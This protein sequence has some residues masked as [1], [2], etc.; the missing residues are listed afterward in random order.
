M[1]DRVSRIAKSSASADEA[2]SVG[3]SGKPACDGVDGDNGLRDQQLVDRCLAGEVAAWE[4]LYSQ[5]HG[6][7]LASIRVLLGHGASDQNLVDEIAARVWYAVVADDGELL[8][9]Y[10]AARG[11]RVI[12]FLRAIAKDLV[13]RHFR[14]ERRRL[15]RETEALLEKPQHD[16][17][18]GASPITSLA[19]FLSTLSPLE[20]TFCDDF[21]LATPSKDGGNSRHTYSETYI[22]QLS[23]R[24]QRKLLGFVHGES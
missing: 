12:T 3:G 18:R 22:R 21:L 2:A 10:E 4:A 19:G 15:Q 6:A 20:R 23:S 17:A 9:R 24:I 13:A 7:L 5:C 11:A 16:T 1:A 14:S 8:T